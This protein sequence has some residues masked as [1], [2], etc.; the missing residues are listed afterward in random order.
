MW[1]IIT[2][3]KTFVLMLVVTVVTLLIEM[4][5]KVILDRNAF[6]S[7]KADKIWLAQFLVFVAYVAVLFFSIFK[8]WNWVYVP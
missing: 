3:D 5:L 8:D 7:K 1:E 2:Q 4:V 6:N